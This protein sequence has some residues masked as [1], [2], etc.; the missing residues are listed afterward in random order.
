VRA[1]HDYL[2]KCNH[3]FIVAN[4]SRAITDQSLQSS[5]F[6]VL[7]RHAPL[8]WEESAAQSLKIAVVCTKTEVPFLTAGWLRSQ[9]SADLVCAVQEIDMAAAR[10]QFCGPGRAIH[11]SV[12]DD[13]DTQIE[14]AKAMGNRTA[15]KA[16]KQRCG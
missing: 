1:T 15:K 12:I 3:I 13:L 4:I 7:S 2:L 6:S 5:L 8:E 16:L 11:P 14:D 9:N 10:R